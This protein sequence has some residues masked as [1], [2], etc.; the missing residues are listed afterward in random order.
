MQISL[1]I[2]ICVFGKDNTDRYQNCIIVE[3]SHI[4][5]I[6]G[7]MASLAIIFVLS[8][9]IVAQNDFSLTI[10]GKCYI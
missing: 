8:R 1:G 4:T 9:I 6:E 2:E 7:F 3:F 10:E 5:L